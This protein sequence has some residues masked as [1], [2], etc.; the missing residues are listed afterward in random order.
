MLHGKCGREIKTHNF[1]EFITASSSQY[2]LPLK[3]AQLPSSWTRLVLWALTVKWHKT[4]ECILIYHFNFID[5]S[6]F[7]STIFLWSR[8]SQT[9]PRPGRINR[10]L[11]LRHDFSFFD[12]FRVLGFSMFN[13]FFSLFPSVKQVSKCSFCKTDNYNPLARS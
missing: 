7:F 9:I 3:I 6:F 13:L 5:F 1:E 10:F 8:S 12:V 2:K 4:E 11:F